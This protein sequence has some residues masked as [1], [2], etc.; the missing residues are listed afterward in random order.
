MCPSCGKKVLVPAGRFDEGCIVGDFIIKGKIGEGSIGAVYRATQISLDRQVALK[1]LSPEYT[2]A[3]G[4][5]DFLKEARAAAKLTHTNLVQSFAVGEEEGICYMAM[6]YIIGETVKTRLKREGKIPID[7]ALHV[8]QQVAEALYYAWDEIAIIH[9]DV[10]PDNIM[11]TEDGIVKLTDLGLAMNQSEWR[12]DMEI[13]GSPSYMSPEQFSGEKLDTR[14]DIYSLGVTLYQMISGKL[15]FDAETVKSVALQHF[16]QDAVPLN[17]LDP[18]IPLKV[19]QLVQKMMAKLPEDRFQNMEELLE[20]IWTIRQKTAPD[21]SLVPDIHTISIK[22]LNYDFQHESAEAKKNVKKLEREIRSKSNLALILLVAVPTAVAL[23]LG[24]VFL[25][26]GKEGQSEKKLEDRV[27]Y[28]SRFATDRSM[29]IDVI[30]SE[31]DKVMREIGTPKNRTQEMLLAKVNAVLACAAKRQAEFEIQSLRA[32]IQNY[33][34]DIVKLN[35][36]IDAMKARVSAAEKNM[37]ENG[38][39]DKLKHDLEKARADLKAARASSDETKAASRELITSYKNICEEYDRLY[40]KNMRMKMLELRRAARFK[41]VDAMLVAESLK[42]G[43][44]L[45]DWLGARESENIKLGKVYNAIAD[46]GTKYSSSVVEGD[47]KVVMISGGAID[48]Q[49]AT[50]RIRQ[51]PWAEMSTDSLWSIVSRDPKFSSQENETRMYI[52]ALKGNIGLASKYA[53]DNRELSELV[54]MLY[55]ESLDTLKYVM[56]SDPKRAELLA[57]GFLRQ[58]E[59]ADNFENMKSSIKALVRRDAE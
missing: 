54:A 6:N 21:K 33:Q 28:L 4:I 3:K 10:K 56:V 46:S 32:G 58:L 15:P 59:G 27:G 18:M 5:I 57:Q 7:E 41:E 52:E 1:I 53:P 42:P 11:I 16:E 55:S 24:A 2:T 48:Y 36:T 19:S 14:S 47:G 38:D 50:G 20:A 37:S 43:G 35:S 39:A 31:G 34:N 49:D 22:R 29:G 44:R 45:K 40:V 30:M 25:F 51:K 26:S 12:E 17:K 13:S 8:I 9:R 23:S